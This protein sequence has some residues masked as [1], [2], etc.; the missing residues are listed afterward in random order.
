MRSL[1]GAARF[2]VAALTIAVAGA[3]AQGGTLGEILGSVLGGGAA[4]VAGTVRGINTSSQQIALQQSNGETVA[5]SFDNQTKVVYQNRSYSVTSLENGD[6]VTARVQQTQ[7]GGYYTDSVQVTQPVSGTSTG[8]SSNVQS[9]QGTVRQIDRTN[10]LFTV[11]AGN[12]VIL[13]VSMPYNASTTDRNRFQN[14]RSGE[15]VRFY[16]EFLTTSRVELRQFN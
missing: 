2:G 3:C 12:G 4:Q 8:G 1:S 14:L 9:L 6:Q 15:Y 10:G 5:L 7:N 13:T 16:G 11:E